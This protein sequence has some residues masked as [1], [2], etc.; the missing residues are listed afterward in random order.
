MMLGFIGLGGMG[1]RMA[2]R[3][4]KAGY[5]LRV[6]NRTTEKAMPLVSLGATLSDSP[7]DL[8]RSVDVVF[9][10]LA[11]D[12]AVEQVL[13][14]PAGVVAQTKPGTSIVDFSSVRPGT[15][16]RIAMAARQ[17]NIDVLDAPVSGSTPQAEDGTLVMF[18]GGKQAAYER[19]RPILGVLAGEVF[20]LGDSGA[21]VTMKLVVNGLLGTGMQ[22]LAESLALGERAGLQKETLLSVLEQTSVLAPGVKRKLQNARSDS[23]PVQFPL[24]LMWKDLNNAMQLAQ[25]RSVPLPLTAA[26]EQVFAIEH[27]H[28][29]EEDV[30]AVIRTMEDLA[31]RIR[32]D[33]DGPHDRK[34][35]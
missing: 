8:A 31:G 28:Q 11:D 13:L 9:S 7:A 12:L 33:S 15:S 29:V 17:R 32:S 25:E 35:A 6:Y 27:A 24:R 22:A 1:S 3:L 4:L 18:V 26:A 2:V 23:Y 10:M 30:S 16:R 34:S 20:Y 5:P 21:G 19:V 14:G